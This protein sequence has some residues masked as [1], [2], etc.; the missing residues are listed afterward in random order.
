MRLRSHDG[1]GIWR[2]AS[3]TTICVVLLGS[4]IL[5]LLRIVAL[6]LREGR[7]RLSI[8]LLILLGLILLLRKVGFLIPLKLWQRSGW[9]ELIVG[10]LGRGIGLLELG[11]LHRRVLLI[12]KWRLSKLC[13]SNVVLTILLA[14]LLDML[15]ELLR[16]SRTDILFLLHKA[17]RSPQPLPVLLDFLKCLV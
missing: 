2:S 6:V 8:L 12:C 15:L 14:G 10:H 4:C 7:C 13:W 3:S 1:G 11:L 16:H 9:R 5:V 17:I